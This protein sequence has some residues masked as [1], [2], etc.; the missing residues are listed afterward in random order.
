MTE[1]R[2]FSL[3]T[4]REQWREQRELGLI[5]GIR[6]RTSTGGKR[7]PVGRKRPMAAAKLKVVDDS[8]H[9][10]PEEL[11]QRA[12]FDDSTA[13]RQDLSRSESFRSVRAGAVADARGSSVV[14]DFRSPTESD[15]RM[16]NS[17]EQVRAETDPVLRF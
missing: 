9:D 8:L 2:A 16:R 17:T 3:D 15:C 13:G 12:V 5:I 6:R 1:S 4:S 11:I 10:E 7:Q 14:C